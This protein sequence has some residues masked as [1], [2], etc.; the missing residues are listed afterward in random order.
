MDGLYQFLHNNAIYI[1]TFIVLVVWVGIFLYLN[2]LDKR[3]KSI[4]KDLKG[5]NNEK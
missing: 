2:N 3:M 4:E 1:V 5:E